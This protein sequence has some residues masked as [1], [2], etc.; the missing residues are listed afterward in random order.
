[1]KLSKLFFVTG[2]T[3]LLGNNLV[4]ML[5]ERGERVRVMVRD[6]DLTEP[7]EG[8]E[9]ERF[10]GDIR[11]GSTLRDGL[12]GC[13][14]VIH[15]A[16]DTHIGWHHWE[17]AREINVQGTRNI[18]EATLYHGARFVYISTVDTLPAALDG[19]PV[20]ETDSGSLKLNCTYVVTKRE[21]EQE[22]LGLVDRGLRATILHPGF[23]MG[24]YDWKPSSGKMLLAV[25]GGMLA[26]PTGGLSGCDVR[27]VATGVLAAAESDYSNGDRFI[28][29]GENMRY[30]AAW[31]LMA[32][33]TGARAPRLPMG[34]LV[35]L[36]VGT[37]ADTVN[38]IRRREG[39]VN[40][41]VLAMSKML[42][43]YD[44]SKAQQL[45]GYPCRPFRES[46]ESAWNWF[47]ST[48]RV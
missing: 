44:S 29:A 42:H 31:K 35:R 10:E 2:A 39:D 7:F 12:Q 38:R 32:E 23:M 27:D 13:T 3:G 5:V 30:R 34:P 22:V 47:Q 40:G 41:A 45:L 17:R 25:A 24:P 4:R 26:A 11:N 15:A 8:L 20:S 16:G 9:I 6:P 21:A 36:V 19:R 18:A 43:Y 14:H 46:I 1:M 37:A 48:G 28:L 33:V